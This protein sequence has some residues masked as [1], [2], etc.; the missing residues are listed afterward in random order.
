VFLWL[1]QFRLFD[2][3]WTW[4]AWALCFVLDDFGYYLFHRSAHRVRWFW[5]SH[6]NHHS[7][8]HYNLSTA[9]RQTWTG[10]QWRW[11]SRSA[12]GLLL[13]AFP[14]DDPDSAGDQPDLPVLDPHR[15]DRRM[16]RWFEAVMNTP[17]HHRVH[18]ATNPIYLD[19]NYAGVFIVWDR[20]LGTFQPSGRYSADPLWHRQAVGQLQPAV[21]SVPRMDRDRPRPGSAM[22]EQ[23]GLSVAPAGLEPRWQPRHLRC[24]ADAVAGIAACSTSGIGLRWFK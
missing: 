21:G 8:Q 5:A 14:G 16:P 23:A 19:R 2:I 13:I 1:Y 7:S 3:P 24:A 4:W 6:V 9:L 22:G 20:L 10:F 18:H 17:S 15:G 12:S 11:A